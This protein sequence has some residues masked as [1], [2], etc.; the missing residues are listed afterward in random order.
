M[1]RNQGQMTKSQMVADL[2]DVLVRCYGAG[3]SLSGAVTRQPKTAIERLHEVAWLNRNDG[4]DEQ[5][6]VL[7]SH[8][9]ATIEK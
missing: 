1:E 3:T 9:F 7:V 5:V 4:I 2:N 8:I 6:N